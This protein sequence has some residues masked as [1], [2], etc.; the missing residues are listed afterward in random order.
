V[1]PS[2]E[3]RATPAPIMQGEDPLGWT[4]PRTLIVHRGGMLLAVAVDD[5]T[6]RVLSVIDAGW[7]S[8]FKVG[9][10][11]LATGLLDGLTIRSAAWWPDRGGWP[12][13]AMGAAAWATAVVVALLVATIQRLRRRVDR[14]R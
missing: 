12:G 1:D 13:W 2:G 6:T 11:Y 9:E 10:I 14:S 3:G 5:G 4:G 7:N 8:N